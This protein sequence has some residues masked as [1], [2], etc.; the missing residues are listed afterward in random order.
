MAYLALAQ[1]NQVGREV[2]AAL[3]WGDRGDTQARRSLSQEL[4]RLRGLFPENI[5]DDFVLEAES[6]AL[7]AGLFEVDVVD[8]E[9]GLDSGDAEAAALYTGELLAGHEAN[10]EDFELNA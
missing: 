3:L 6:V 8:F 10:Q 4:Y 9:H 1:G 5:Q 2:L 7:E